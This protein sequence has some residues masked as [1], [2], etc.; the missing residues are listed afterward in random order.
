[1]L[2]VEIV[3]EDTEETELT[4]V[5]RIPS[6]GW[7]WSGLQV[8]SSLL[9]PSARATRKLEKGR[10]GAGKQSVNDTISWNQ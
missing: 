4:S 5:G 10:L 6:F 1:M 8:G 9:S 3:R 2:D 7:G